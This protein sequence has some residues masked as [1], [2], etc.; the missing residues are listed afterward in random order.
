M[1]LRDYL[2][3]LRKRWWVYVLVA[4]IAATSAYVYS[5]SQQPLYRSSA[6][7]YVTPARPDYGVTLVIQNLIRQYSQLLESDR[8]LNSVSTQLE[9]DLPPGTLRQRIST[10]GAAD[11]LMIQV[12]VDDPDPAQ[13]QAIAKALAEQ[14]LADQ[15]ARME[16]VDPRDKIDIRKYDDPE[17][18]VLHSP[19]TRVNV[20]A[21]A[22]LGLLLGGVIAFGLEYLDDTIKSSDDVER[23]MTLPVVGSIPNIGGSNG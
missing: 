14:F 13:A 2:I 10:S 17:P 3:V 19:Q 8:F 23:H 15:Q 7:L 9:L 22:I 18:G 16:Q 4:I 6:K 20:V 5:K 21:G 11:S 12:D 1:P